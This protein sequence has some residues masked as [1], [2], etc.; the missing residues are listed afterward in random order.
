VFVWALN[1]VF[2]TKELGIMRWE[3]V[4]IPRRYVELFERDVD[5][6]YRLPFFSLDLLSPI[7]SDAQSQVAVFFATSPTA[8]IIF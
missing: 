5:A 2:A 4:L 1:A 3:H 6:D 8:S 7:V